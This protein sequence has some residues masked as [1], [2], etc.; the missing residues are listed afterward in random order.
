MWLSGVSNLGSPIEPQECHARTVVS[1]A[2]SLVVGSVDV[3][4]HTVV[5]GM[6]SI[7]NFQH[8][9]EVT[10]GES[11]AQVQSAPDACW[12]RLRTVIFAIRSTCEDLESYKTDFQEDGE[13][14]HLIKA[15]EITKSEPSQSI[16]PALLGALS[17]GTH[18]P[19]D[20]LGETTG[21]G[22]R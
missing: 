16:T 1:F 13:F 5:H 15:H 4:F 18:S 12:E 17:L 11:G 6:S 9:E 2:A 7:D 3:L 20:N 19:R 14:R 8:S 22:Y 21:N 10:V